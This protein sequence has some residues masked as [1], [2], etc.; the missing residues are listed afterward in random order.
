MN[1]ISIFHIICEVVSRLRRTPGLVCPS[2]RGLYWL[3][4]YR[5]NYRKPGINTQIFH[6]RHI[7]FQ[8]VFIVCEVFFKIVTHVGPNL[9]KLRGSYWRPATLPSD[10]TF[11][12]S[13]HS[14]WPTVGAGWSNAKAGIMVWG[15]RETRHNW[16]VYGAVFCCKQ[17]DNHL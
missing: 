16:I 13:G 15:G 6:S 11:L 7:C 5:Q 4:W 10:R 8:Q 14:S 17:E 2:C 1:M 9:S 12:I 3:L